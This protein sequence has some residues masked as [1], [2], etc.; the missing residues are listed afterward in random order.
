M[1]GT[2]SPNIHTIVK[3]QIVFLLSTLTEENFERNQVEIRSLSEQHGIDTYLHFIRRLIVHSHSRLTSTASP[4]AFDQSAALTFRLLVQETQRLARDP[5]LADR[6]RDGIDRGE[7]DVFRNFDFIKFADRIGLRPLERLILASSILAAPTRK[8][9]AA[10]AA[11]VIRVDFENAVLALCQHPSFDHADLN[12]NQVAKLLSN[13]LAESPLDAPVLDAPQRQALILAAQTKYGSE[14]VSPILQRI[15]PNMSLPAG[16]SLIQALV[17]LGAEVTADPDV[18]RALFLRFSLTENNPPTDAQ[19]VEIVTTLAKLAPE[20]TTLPDVG[21][22]VR[23]LS[24]LNGDLNWPA[25]IEA[26]DMPERQGVDTAT[27]KLLI[28]ILMNAPR[29]EKPHAVTGFWHLWSNTLYQLRL[30]DALLSLPADTFNFV[31]LPGRKIVTVEDVAGASPTIKSLAANVQGHTWNSLDL[32]EVLVQAADL[33][34]PDVQIVVQDMLDKAVKISAELVHMG[35]LQVPQSPWNEIRLDYTQRLLAMFLAGHPNHQLVFMRIWQ[36]EPSYLTNAFRDFYEES[37]LNITRIL[38]VAQDLKILDSLLEVRPFTFA[39]DVAALASRREYLNLDK[40]LA[41]NVSA[42]G[43]DFL[44]AVIAFLDLKMESEKAQ[45]VSDPPVDPRTM[46]LSPQTITIFLRVLRNSSAIMHES[47]VD[48]CLEVR[49]ACLQIHPRLMNLMPGSDTEPGF[50]VVSYSA[51]IETEVDGIYKQMYDEQITIDDVIK[52]LQRNKTSSNPRDHEIFSC[53]LHFLFDEYKFFQHCYPP[54]ELAMTGYLFGSLIQYQLVDFIPLGIAIRYVLDA[55][56]CPPETNLF[57]FG[58]QALSRFESRLAE[59]QPL[60]QALL[61]IPHLLEARPDLAVVI[62][63]ALVNGDDTSSSADLRTLQAAPMPEPPP[64]FTAIQ[65]DRLEG[66]P[67]KPPEEVSDKILFIVNNLAPSNFDAKLSEMKGHFQEQYSRWFA[68]YLVDQ[69]VSIE[70]N[71]HQLYLRFLDALDVRPLYRFVLHETL[72]KSAALLNSEK[73]MQL[74]SERAILKNVGSWLGSITLARDRP[75]KHK[76]LSFKDLLVEG[77]DNGRLIVAIPFVCKTLEPAAR[78]KVFRPPNPWLMAVISLLTELYHFAELKLNLKFE[79]EMLCKALDV[80]LDVVQATTILRNR[81]LTDSLSGPPLPDYVGDIDS[82]PMGGYDPTAQTAGDAQV[83]PLGPASPSETQRVLGA[84]IESILSSILPHVTISP[85]LAP[86]NTN[87]SFKR[88][89]HMAIDRAVR[90]IILPVVERSVTIAG[91]STRELVA[92]DFVT[93]ANEDKMRKAGH[94]M[95]QRLAGSLALVTC[96]EPLKGNLGSHLRQFLSEFGFTEQMVP[97]Q[98][99]FLLVQDNIELACQAIEK[100]AMDRAVIDVDEG[101]ATAYEVRRRHREQRPGQP[102]WDSTALQSSIVNSLPDPLRIKPTGV[103]PNQLRVYEEFREINDP[104]RM[105]TSRPN[106]TASYSRNDQ[107]ASLYSPSPMPEQPAQN[108]MRPQEAMERFNAL[109]RD[110]EAI[111]LQLPITSLAALPP[112]HEVRHLVR[113]ILFLAVDSADRTRTPLLMS[114]KIVQLL[115]KTPSQ[116]GREIYVAL[117]DQLCH[118]FEDVAT[119]A[120]TWLVYAE[121]ERKFN[122]PVTVTLLRSGLVSIAQEDQQLARQ[123]YTDP[124]STLQNFAAGLIRECLAA[125]PPLATQAQFSYSLEIL[126]QLAQSGKANDEVLRLLDDLRGVRRPSQTATENQPVRQPS[127]KPE[128]ETL[129]EKLFIWFQQ[130]VS[131]YQRSHSPEKS[132]VPYITQLTRQGILK[133]EDTSS[134]FFRV[135]AESSVNS[136]IKHVNAGEFGFAFQALDAMS[137]LIVYI[138]KYHG[139]ASGV[140]NDQAKVHYLTKILTIFVLVLANMHEEQGPH[141]Q[142]K[143][144]FRFFS[145]LLNDLHSIESSLGTAYFQLLLAIGDTFSS[146]QPTYFPGFAFSWMSLISHRLFM[147]KLL[148]PDNRQ[149]WSAFY[150]L[151]LSLFKFLGPFLKTA[152]LQSAGRDLYRGTLRLLLVL[153]HDFPE[154]LAEYY[155]SLCDAIPSRCIQLRN[156]ILSAYPPNIILPDPHLPDIDFESIPEMGP[157]PHILSDFAASLRAGD[158]KMYLDQYLL[159]R[160]SQ[161]TFLPSLKDRLRLPAQEGTT[162]TYNLSLINSLVIYIGV[163]SVA[164]ARA[165]SA[166]P[167]FVPTDPGVVAL[168]YLAT[169]LDVEGQ[170]HLLSAMVLH[171]RYPNAHT[172]WFSSLML[173]LFREIEADNFREVMTRVLLERFL[174]HRPHPWGALVTFIELL[175]NPKYQFRQQEFINVAPEVTFLLENVRVMLALDHAVAD[176]RE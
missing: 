4:A 117:L 66:E 167:L 139:D 131:I 10:Q 152:D 140:N 65:P 47:D 173:Y 28:A 3:A 144:F 132:F 176:G 34:N 40:W 133:A 78:S 52:L 112:N 169:N 111:L 85:Q 49:N 107:L 23:V 14:I 122:V 74:G 142:Q 76:N 21:A 135:C 124:R 143:P 160:N 120:I 148:L 98:I 6:F 67:E 159:N 115:Y 81:P 59:W 16:T 9:L 166:G 110:L 58:L 51:E 20:G 50:A 161:P 46:Q 45:R 108:L 172:H 37:P 60:C 94:L 30:L 48:Y 100:A 170:Y 96:K 31:N 164:Q 163:S 174:V 114:Q 70:P 123:L 102:F 38:D 91:I 8:E 82:L 136:Y 13:L 18:V 87:P 5:F 156:I 42:H 105:F 19:V 56:G 155:F 83:L 80:D 43:A 145:S 137:R 64:V 104:K 33:E 128:T 41:D 158:L 171:L 147:P 150:K 7:G 69:R 27:L 141:F 86:L 79:I 95:A 89:V 44:H 1:D 154:F 130:W 11:T 99:I 75:I 22:V 73:T 72:V 101:F 149:G 151:L 57:K 63:R 157:I 39:L 126:T 25:A 127:V 129:R 12:P 121:D 24:S 168:H 162:E 61:K 103:Q 119:E 15:L 125:D 97:D 109:I 84:H 71:N 53:M 116:L 29:N 77:Y 90:E 35:L 62:Q 36:I 134:F 54:R 26:F 32:F 118:S 2:A 138:I 113:Q 146:L 93:E 106:S 88:A 175:R 153:L 92:K 68:N 165:R 17:Q 55:L